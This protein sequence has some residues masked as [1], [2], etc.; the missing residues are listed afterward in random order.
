MPWRALLALLAAGVVVAA[1]VLLARVADRPDPAV[2]FA[3]GQAAV[4]AGNY[5]A[6]RNHFLATV[7]AAPADAR[8]QVALATTYLVLGD[9]VAAGGALDR[10]VAAGVPR[11][12]LHASRAAALLL[13]DDA[14]AALA[15]AR[16]APADPA[17]RR[18]AARALA[19]Q[20]DRPA[21]LATLAA[22][23][24]ARPADPGAWTDLGRIRLDVGDVGGASEAAVRASTLAPRDL[25]ALTLRGEIVRRRYGL[26]AAMPWFDAALARDAYYVPALLE[27]AATLGDIGRYVDSLSAARR[28]LAARPGDAR[29]LYLMAVIA[30]RAGDATLAAALL[31]RTGGAMDGVPG[32]LLLAG[33]VDFSTG[34]HEQAVVR[35]R[36]LLDRQP[37]NLVAR[38]LLGAALL[39]SGDATGALAVLRPV[40]LRADADTYTLTL[41][42]RAFEARG[43]RGWTAAFIDRA[44]TAPAGA[45]TPFGQDE[46]AAVLA[47]AMARAPDDPRVAVAAI[48]GALDRGQ[49]AAALAMADRIVRAAPGAPAAQQLWG[50]VARATGRAGPA[51]AAYARAADLRFD[52]PAMLRLVEARAPAD[53][54]GAADTLALYLAQNP[55][56]TDARRALANVQTAARDDGAIATLEGLRGDLGNRDAR[57]LAQLAHAYVAA[58]DP[59]AALPYAR[60]AYRLQ[61]MSAAATDAYG[62]ALFDRGDTPG[63]LQLLRKAAALAPRAAMIRWHLGQALAD[64]GRTAEARAAIMTALADPG[65]TE[66]EAAGRL[67]MAIRPA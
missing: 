12:R 26:I 8:A 23:V 15:E 38:R 18:V 32:A 55:V 33:A 44:A 60:A 61:P 19:A 48:R 34:R 50:D 30:A 27:R 10:A 62:H 4:R 66:R 20:G 57:L 25:P 24:R 14:D 35:W 42:A 58:G 52:S 1:V 63:A 37:M 3:E 6:A 5:S 51:L 28:V 21:A 17:A 7:A 54:V 16:R 22:L 29:A 59:A 65:F 2:A 39:R 31:D 45:A 56:A 67:L 49:A 53:R 36:A 11:D 40:A 47:T 41:V 43:E 64:A 46:D 13:Q 9:G